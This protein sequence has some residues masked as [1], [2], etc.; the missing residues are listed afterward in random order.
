MKFLHIVLFTALFALPNVYADDTSK[1]PQ[2]SSIEFKNEYFYSKEGVFLKEKAK[3][4]IIALMNYHG[5]PVYDGIRDDIWAMDYG[6]GHFAEVGL[7][8]IMYENNKTNM[9]MLLDLF[10][11][12]NQMLGEH[13]HVDGVDTA[14]KREGWLLRWGKSY[15]A[16]IGEDN[17]A[18]FPEVKIP[19]SHWDGKV[20]SKH[21]IEALPGSFNSL[22]EVLSN[23]WQFAGKEGAIMTE[24][25]N[26]ADSDAVKRTDPKM[27]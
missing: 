12:P 14:A 7:S 24:V 21:I 3:D 23:H 22:K 5:Y 27:K 15:V 18:D 13:R 19:K 1:K 20:S 4:A 16:G 17:M 6:V 11:L 25:A 8:G 26:F 9:Y 10:L 2:L